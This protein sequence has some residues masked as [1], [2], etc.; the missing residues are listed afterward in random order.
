MDFK[1]ITP[2][3]LGALVIAIGLTG[4]GKKKHST[5]WDHSA[6][7]EHEIKQTNPLIIPPDFK[8]MPPPDL[9]AELAV[10][11]LEANLEIKE[12]AERQ[13]AEKEK[14]AKE[15]ELQRKKKQAEKTTK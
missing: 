11:N 14:R 13:K 6:L 7:H 15:R 1:K 10:Q 8:L 5:A 4:C 9:E 12:R 2:T 3:F